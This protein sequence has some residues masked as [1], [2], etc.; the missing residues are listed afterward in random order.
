MAGGMAGGANGIASAGQ[1]PSEGGTR[2]APPSS[3]S[4]KAAA[5]ARSS[6][7]WKLP[8]TRPPQRLRGRADQIRAAGALG[9]SRLCLSPM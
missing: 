1:P 2:S 3:R 6:T 8:A 4:I 9:V 7:T 5:A